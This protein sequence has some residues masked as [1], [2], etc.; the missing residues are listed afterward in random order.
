MHDP[1]TAPGVPAASTRAYR[2]YWYVRR[3]RRAAAEGGD[4]GMPSRRETIV[5]SGNRFLA[6]SAAVHFAW[7]L[8]L[9][10]GDAV[11]PDT[12]VTVLTDREAYAAPAEVEGTVV[13]DRS[14][15]IFV[16]ACASKIGFSVERRSAGRDW[17]EAFGA[18]VACLAKLSM[19]PVEIAPGARG[20]RG[21][22]IREP[23]TYRLRTFFTG[24]RSGERFVTRVS[25]PFVVEP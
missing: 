17:Q 25:A 18:G 14:S 23:G 5:M 7:V 4:D 24:S 10:C 16:T 6:A 12:G 9:G 1:T 8:G 19:V 15:S 20:S 11:E 2:G 21:V 3:L 13:N 22:S